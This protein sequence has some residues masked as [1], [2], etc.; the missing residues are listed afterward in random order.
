[1]T[2]F[3]DVL[4]ELGEFGPWQLWVTL[5][6]WVP[7]LMAGC[8]ILMAS[9]TALL[10]TAFRCAIPECDEDPTNFTFATTVPPSL[11]F[12]TDGGR[13]NHCSYYRPDSSCLATVSPEVVACPPGGPFAFD[14]ESFDMSS[15]LVTEFGL[16][17]D[18]NKKI[19]VVFFNCFF[20]A[21]MGLGSFG[22]G[23]LSDRVGR[24]HT[25]LFSTLTAGVASLGGSLAP[26]YISYALLQL[27]TGCGTAGMYYCAFTM[28]LEVVGTSQRPPG[29][30][31]VSYTTLQVTAGRGHG[32][33][34]RV[35][36]YWCPRRRARCL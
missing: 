16:V 15:S 25:L 1:M 5:L 8:M 3:S 28:V 36:S 18:K 4:K 14:M 35:C 13:A 21:G 34:R 10:P 32:S 29:V 22:S 20:M 12:P 26:G 33:S 30:Y 11:L 2:K 9:W 17:C 7:A 6:C 27:V 31:W 19:W 23:L 24:R